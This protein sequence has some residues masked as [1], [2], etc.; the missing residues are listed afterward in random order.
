MGY[1]DARVGG[2]LPKED[3]YRCPAGECL[4]YRF[5][6]EEDGKRLRRYWTTDDDVPEM[7]DIPDLFHAKGVRKFAIGRF[8]KI[9]LSGEY[10]GIPRVDARGRPQRT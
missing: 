8:T 3:A 2:Y 10:G 7:I 4:P 1:G 6:N 5:T 9:A